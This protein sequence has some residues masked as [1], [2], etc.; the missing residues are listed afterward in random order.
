[1]QEKAE[2]IC[3]LNFDELNFYYVNNNLNMGTDKL[4]QFMPYYCFLS[5][6]VLVLLQ[7]VLFTA[8][9]IDCIV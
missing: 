3:K 7:G 2:Y 6:Y 9:M 1:M 8:L 4:A 5:S